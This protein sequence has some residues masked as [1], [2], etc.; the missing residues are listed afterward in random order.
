MSEQKSTARERST[1]YR[2]PIQTIL[3][4][5]FVKSEEEFSPSYISIQGKK[6][7][8]V[9]VVGIIVSKESSSSL[10]IIDDGSDKIEVRGFEQ[11]DLS[12]VQ[13]GDLVV[14]IGR[15]REYNGQRY[16]MPE[17]ITKTSREWMVLRKKELEV[18]GQGPLIEQ[19]SQVEVEEIMDSSVEQSDND[20]NKYEQ[21]LGVI[22]SMDKGGGVGIEVITDTIKDNNTEEVIEH[23]LKEGELFENR[24]GRL[25][26]LE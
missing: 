13:I 17:I 9:N 26:I 18:L 8:R 24:P 6:I 5:E 20:S 12:T 25:K 23:M 14:V 21:V 16:L 2:I 4:G 1:A 22:R 11:L 10:L 19:E 3:Q 7:S 15:I